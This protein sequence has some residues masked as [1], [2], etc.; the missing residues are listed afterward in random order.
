MAGGLR[1]VNPAIVYTVISGFGIS[2]V[3]LPGPYREF[4]PNDFLDL[5]SGGQLYLTGY[6]DRHPV[7]A[8]GP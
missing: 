2:G 8:G 1:T 7:Q 4:R 3:G 5:A 6:P